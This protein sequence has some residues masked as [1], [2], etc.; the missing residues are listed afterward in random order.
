MEYACAAVGGLDEYSTY[1]TGDQLNDLYSQI[2]GNFVG[3]GIELK[4]A[5]GSLLIVNVITGS[6]A[7]RGGIKPG[8]QDHQ[9]SADIRPTI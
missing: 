2:E 1:L 3:L 8:D 7:Q 4:A 9:P 5:E 6:P